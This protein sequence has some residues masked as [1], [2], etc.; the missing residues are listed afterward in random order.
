MTSIRI[1]ANTQSD[2][3]RQGSFEQLPHTIFLSCLNRFPHCTIERSRPALLEKLRPIIRGA[4]RVQLVDYIVFT[5]W[6][7]GNANKEN[8]LETVF[9]LAEAWLE[10]AK[11]P[12]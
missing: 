2:G 11:D 10:T 4:S 8:F 6:A 1:R 9:A 3:H 12:V 7:K 5:S